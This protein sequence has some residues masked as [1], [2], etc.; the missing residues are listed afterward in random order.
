[1]EWAINRI[2]YCSSN[3]CAWLGGGRLAVG[4]KN[5]RRLSLD[6][7]QL[8]I[9]AMQHACIS[10]TREIDNACMLAI[11]ARMLEQ[12]GRGTWN[13]IHCIFFF[14]RFF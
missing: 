6:D 8:Y 12:K 2:P 7:R 4:L 1:M 3:S 5:R 13:I 14:L 10:N 9:H 11:A